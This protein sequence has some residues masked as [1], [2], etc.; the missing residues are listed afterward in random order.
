MRT[1]KTL[2]RLARCPG[3][4]VFA[5]RRVILLVCHEVAHIDKLSNQKNNNKIIYDIFTMQH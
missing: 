1:A 4:S 2:I 5:G 3:R